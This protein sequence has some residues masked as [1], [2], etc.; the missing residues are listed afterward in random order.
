MSAD[1]PINLLLIALISVGFLEGV[2]LHFK[3]SQGYDWKAYACSVVDGLGRVLFFEGPIVLLIFGPLLSWATSHRVAQMPLDGWT[4]FLCLFVGEEFFYYWYHRACHRI[5]WFWAGHKPHH[6]PEDLLLGH[7]Y[8]FGWTAALS[9]SRVFFIPLVLVGFPFE[10]I[11]SMLYLNLA[12]Q[13][14]V[15]NTWTPKLGWLE[16]VLNTPSN[17]RVHHAVNPEY[18]DSNFGGVLIVFDRIFGTYVPE[19]DDV[20]CQYGLLAPVRSRNPIVTSFHEWWMLLRDLRSARS[21]SDV[22][23]Y[24]FGRPG[25]KPGREQGLGL[26]AEP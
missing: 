15:H 7:A 17:H 1:S 13:F 6:T 22:A 11:L 14:W 5:R 9:G 18:I 16:Y 3:R 19:R 2:V 24:L 4:A 26:V 25:W 20:P 23:G 21:V 8:R 10:A 12:Y